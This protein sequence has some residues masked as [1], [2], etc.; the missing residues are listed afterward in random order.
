MATSHHERLNPMKTNELKNRA[1][2]LRGWAAGADCSDAQA[3]QQWSE[4]SGALS[5]SE[6]DEC[7][8]GGF[9]TGFEMGKAFREHFET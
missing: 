3:E 4:D 2:F 1:K 9:E 7:Y 8:D 6:R 5:K